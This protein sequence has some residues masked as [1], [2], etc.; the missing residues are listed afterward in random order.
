MPNTSIGQTK[1]QVPIAKPVGAQTAPPSGN[2]SGPA[3]PQVSVPAPSPLI[4]NGKA[5]ASIDVRSMSPSDIVSTINNAGI[6]G[7]TASIDGQGRLVIT[8]IFSI[9]GD[10]NL[11]AILG[12]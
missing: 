7:V 4:I 10:G 2:P 1:L 11:R 3:A 6:A 8:G 12:V 5:T 9:G